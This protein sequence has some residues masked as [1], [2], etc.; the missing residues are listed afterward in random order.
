MRPG[1]RKTFAWCV[2]DVVARCH[3]ARDC[4]TCPLWADCGGRA[5]GASGF[6]PVEDVIAMHGRVSRATWEHEMLCRPPRAEHAVFPG[7]ARG[8]H[9]CAFPQSRATGRGEAVVA[10]GRA[11]VCEAVVAGVDFGFAAA[12]VCLWVVMLK[13]ERG[14]RVAW[15]VDEL[16]AARRTLRQNAEAMRARGGADGGFAPAVVYCDVAGRGRNG[17]TGRTDEAVLRGEG[18]TVRSG[19]MGIVESLALV[20]DLV[21]PAEEGAAPRLLVDPRCERL[22]AAFE[23]YAWKRPGEE[24]LKDGVH[25]HLIDALRYALFNH[26][27]PRGKVEVLNY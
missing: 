1:A 27:R 11:L 12:F 19:P 4:G 13:D 20:G 21:E 2:W 17:Q 14:R 5:K 15:V 22:I 7:F 16:V 8:R 6:V 25:D 10:G 18:F 26:D 24:A 9:V 3:P 23:G